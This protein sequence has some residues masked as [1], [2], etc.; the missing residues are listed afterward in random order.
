MLV[1]GNCQAP[2]VKNIEAG[3]QAATM[4]M[5]PVEEGKLAAA[6]AK[7]FFEGRKPEKI[8]HLAT[9]TITKANIAKY[10]APCS[11]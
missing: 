3:K 11:Y 5:L 2:G 8:T 6:K 7:E 4:L 10:A 9:D 1:L